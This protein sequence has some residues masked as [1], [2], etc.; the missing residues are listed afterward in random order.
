MYELDLY[1]ESTEIMDDSFDKLQSTGR[2]SLVVC[3]ITFMNGF[4]HA[5]GK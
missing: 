1:L 4:L 5:I 3:F 2:E